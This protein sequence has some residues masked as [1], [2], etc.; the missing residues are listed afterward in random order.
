M[1]VLCITIYYSSINAVLLSLQS[2][3]MRKL[4][5]KHN[6]LIDAS[7]YLSLFEQRVILLALVEA[8]EMSNLTSET[9]VTITAESYKEQYNVTKREAYRHLVEAGK[10]LFERKFTFIEADGEK[11]TTSRW[12]N[13]ISQIEGKAI[14]EMTLNKN[15]VG[16]ISRLTNNF[17][18]YLLNQVS[19][20]KSQYSIRLYEIVIKWASQTKTKKYTVDEIRSL[21]G[22]D[23]GKY[24]R[25]SNFKTRILNVAI[26]EINE[27]S[28]IV[29]E[30]E[31]F[32]TGR[33]V[34]H[35]QFK[36]TKQEDDKNKV[37]TYTLTPKQIGMFGDRLS[38][39][40]EF[41]NHFVAPSGMD[42]DEYSELICEKLEEEFYVK[43]WMEFLIKV[44]FKPKK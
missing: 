42:L 32:K 17:T 38:R 26:D 22:A 12:V 4:V 7:F 10:R 39:M 18:R 14:I 36:I 20:F 30:Y 19:G 11:I 29:I 37:Q 27:K 2:A 34:T 23:D 44:G 6:S 41:Q 28:D 3:L 5:V 21:L 1:K 9:K 43:A 25:I 16:M 31:Q 8:R 40:E 13:E 33:D 35:F 24:E 15:I